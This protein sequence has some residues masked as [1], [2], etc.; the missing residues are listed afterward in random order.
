[1][2]ETGLVNDEAEYVYEIKN[3]Y[4]KADFLKVDKATGDAVAGAL[5][6][7]T[8][9]K[10]TVIDTWT[11]E[12]TAHRINRLRSGTYTLTELKA[13]EGYQKGAPIKCVVQERSAVQKFRLKDVKMVLIKVK[14][15]LHGKE[16]V[17]AHG[18]PTFTFQVEGVDLDGKKWVLFDTVEF[19]QEDDNPEADIQ[20]EV[21]FTVPAG[22]YT[23][24]EQK[25]F[26]YELEKIESVRN[27]T[28][29][30][31][32]VEFDLTN[33]QNGMTAFVNKKINDSYLTHTSFVRNT[34]IKE[35][36]K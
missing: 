26:R 12:K 31:Q 19:T 34:V 8:D 25:T 11:S 17:W 27:G 1:M 5:L 28:V 20:K 4:I 15:V 7:L 16:I 13:P 30:E 3:A 23:V 9:E 6:Q 36:N 24:C 2:S 18:N 32:K 29:K 33:N 10:G 35:K 14:K 22:T 21:L